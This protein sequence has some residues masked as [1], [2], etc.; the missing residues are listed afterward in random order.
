MSK[1]SKK[2]VPEVE[3]CNKM[4][5]LVALYKKEIAKG[6]PPTWA[7]DL[8]N[9]H[10]IMLDII[11]VTMDD[12]LLPSD[13][14]NITKLW[15]ESLGVDSTSF[16]RDTVGYNPV[17]NGKFEYKPTQPSYSPK[18]I[19]TAYSRSEQIPIVIPQPKLK[20]NIKSTRNPAIRNRL[21]KKRK[22]KSLK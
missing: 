2:K 8:L 11:P 7:S 17:R 9:V 18:N 22:M 20:G 1:D 6:Y 5:E 21:L 15:E 13:Y 14:K 10:K 16:W 19:P 3:L 4:I 12:Y